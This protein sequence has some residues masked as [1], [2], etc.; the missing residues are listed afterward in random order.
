MTR[1]WGLNRSLLGAAIGLM[2]TVGLAVSAYGW[3]CGSLAEEDTRIAAARVASKDLAVSL[4][5]QLLRTIKEQGAVAAIPFCHERAPGISQ[6]LSESRGWQIGRTGLRVRNPQNA[7]DE[8]ERNVLEK[9]QRRIAAGE[10]VAEQ[11]FWQICE[12]PDGK[13]EFRYMKALPTDEVCLVCHGSNIE[14]ELADTIDRLY[15]QDQARGFERGQ[16]RGAVTII[17]TLDSKEDTAEENS[18]EKS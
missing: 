13:R 16:L 2:M 6:T 14:P 1:N 12:A 18:Q 11:E 5:G 4:K 8:W 3:N 10:D 17:R 7:P 15:P 9:F